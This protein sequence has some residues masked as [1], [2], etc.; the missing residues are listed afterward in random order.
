MRIL[1]PRRRSGSSVSRREALRR[2]TAT[3]LTMWMFR[4]R[5]LA[6]P[7]VHHARFFRPGP[8]PGRFFPVPS[9]S[10]CFHPG[11][12]DASLSFFFSDR[13]ASPI[14]PGLH[15]F[16]SSSRLVWIHFVVLFPRRSLHVTCRTKDEACVWRGRRVDHG[17]V[18]LFDTTS[19]GRGRPASSRMVPIRT[20]LGAFR[21]GFVKTVD[22]RRGGDP[23]W[24]GGSVGTG[25]FHLSLPEGEGFPFA[26]FDGE[27]AGSAFVMANTKGGTAVETI[28]L[29]LVCSMATLIRL[30]SV[31][32]TRKT[33]RKERT[34]RRGPTRNKTPT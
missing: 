26:P 3:I 27:I 19:V 15:V 22:T 1:L 25:R 4:L 33:C 17:P 20:R 23:P 34:R 9:G 5:C 24:A 21:V 30:F 11:G 10:P 14:H 12:M 8:L 29:V 6:P 32:G 13:V 2:V 28:A 7:S 18:P 16:R 31:R